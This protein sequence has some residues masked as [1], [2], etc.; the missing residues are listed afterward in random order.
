MTTEPS[1]VGR[2]V[3]AESVDLVTVVDA[4][5]V[6]QYQNPASEPV[7]GYGPERL[8]GAHVG[9][10][11]HPEDAS[12]A[13]GLFERGEDSQSDDSRADGGTEPLDDATE[14]AD[15][16]RPPTGDISQSGAAS[17]PNEATVRV[18]A[19]DDSW[20]ALATRS[21]GRRRDDLGGYVV[22]SRP[23]GTDDDPDSG[24]I[25][26]RMTD[27]FLALDEDWRVVYANTTA[28]EVIA[29]ATGRDP[30]ESVVGLDFWAVMPDAEETPFYDRYEEAVT[31]GESVSFEEYYAP[32]DTWF[33]VRAYPSPSGLSVYFRDCTEER[34]TREALAHRE[35]V[36]R[37][38]HDVIADREKSFREQVRT[39]LELG[40]RELDMT[41]ATLS[42]IDGEE[43]V[44]EVVSS[45]DGSV[46]EGDVAP[47]AATNCEIVAADEESLALGDVLRDAPEQADRAGYTGWGI[48]CYLG[49]PVFLGD[50]VYGTFC[51]FDTEPRDGQFSDWEVTFVDLLSQW[52]SYE[53][54]RERRREELAAQNDRLEEFAS[55]VSHDLRNPLNV[56]DGSLELVATSDDPEH[57]ERCRRSVE[58]METM[59]DELL[60][61]ARSG[62]LR[63]DPA[64]QSLE[65]VVRESWDQVATAD[66]TL[67]VE[68]TATIRADE[69]RLRQLVENLLR[70]AV[71][72]GGED[73]TVTV[74]TTDDGFTVG[75]DGP[76]IPPA[77][78]E[79]VLESGYSTEPDGTGYGLGI[80]SEIAAAH[81]WTVEVT[82]SPADGAEFVFAGV[83]TA[84]DE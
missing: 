5:G 22:T 47:T 12:R 54:Q 39:L 80:V 33:D 66:A 64:P 24:E 18:R 81:G 40:R 42:H 38:I 23:V 28:R 13:A 70:N 65:T 4:D 11:L 71:Q 2:A 30:D 84:A 21:S 15:G 29:T 20:V 61:L 7:L 34:R 1:D 62:E 27:G 73:V 37:E 79:Q 72:H 75:D 82:E 60:T 76:G 43:Y 45:G 8:E 6:V 10:F 17:E 46:A 14:S 41:N 35:T 26:D 78:R 57:L 52:A 83:E 19:A 32:L 44:F 31:T 3:L 53:L 56:L 67:R 74:R 16:D 69:T 48:T 77:D 36:L 49:A 25:L 55:I 63:D 58:R 51:F 9:E 68:G 59:I 50:E